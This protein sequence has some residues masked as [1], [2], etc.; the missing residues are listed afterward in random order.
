MKEVQTHRLIWW[1][2]AEVAFMIAI[3]RSVY[4]R[5]AKMIQHVLTSLFRLS[6]GTFLTNM[7]TS[8]HTA[9]SWLI[10]ST[11]ITVITITFSLMLLNCFEKW[12]NLN[13]FTRYCWKSS[14]LTSVIDMRLNNVVV[15][16]HSAYTKTC[17]WD[18]TIPLKSIITFV[19]P[20]RTFWRRVMK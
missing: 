13:Y 7:T 17:L 9:F 11:V 10:L 6:P 18:W 3:Y 12:K 19:L 20:H 5:H 16:L 1:N 14:P 2:T 15:G 4:V 8:A